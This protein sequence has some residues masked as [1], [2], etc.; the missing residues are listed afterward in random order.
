MQHRKLMQH[1]H[2]CHRNQQRVRS[3]TDRYQWR[4]NCIELLVSLELFSSRNKRR[5]A[6]GVL[7]VGLVVSGVL[8]VG[9]GGGAGWVG[10][11][12]PI[13]SLLCS[14]KWGSGTSILPHISHWQLRFV[15]CFSNCLFRSL[16]CTKYSDK[17]LR[18]CPLVEGPLVKGER[19]ND[20]LVG[21]RTALPVCLFS[22]KLEWL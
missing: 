20:D 22:A 1:Q 21:F 4:P 8:I 12:S 19:P 18:H 13:H 2:K 15:G 3:W 7:I 17:R 9:L 16:C 11:G 10:T 14:C 5:A 6:C